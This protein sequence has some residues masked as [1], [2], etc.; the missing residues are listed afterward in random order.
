MTLEK[1]L[2]TTGY[3]RAN[4]SGPPV[5]TTILNFLR[6]PWHSNPMSKSVRSLTGLGLFNSSYTPGNKSRRFPL[7]YFQ[8]CKIMA[9]PS[10]CLK[11]QRCRNKLH[12]E[13][14]NQVPHAVAPDCRHLHTRLS[15]CEALLANG[16]HLGKSVR[17]SGF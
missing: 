9:A 5:K 14:R 1:D 13:L 10:R 7:T 4:Y 12:R 11:L 17:S 3:K 8:E 15:A 2:A 6:A 16:T